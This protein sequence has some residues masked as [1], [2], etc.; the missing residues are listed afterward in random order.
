MLGP[1]LDLAAHQCDGI[2]RLDG[3]WTDTC[4]SEQRTTDVTPYLR[5]LARVL[6]GTH[7]RGSP[8]TSG[9][10]PYT[11]RSCGREPPSASLWGRDR[12]LSAEPFPE[13][14]LR[15]DPTGWEIWAD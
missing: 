2:V 3:F 9:R 15:L 8:W 7:R 11:A 5:G 1:Y 14:S 6:G 13:S 4:P 10:A 12:R